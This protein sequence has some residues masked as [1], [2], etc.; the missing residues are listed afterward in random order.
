MIRQDYDYTPRK[1]GKKTRQGT[2]RNTKYGNMVSKKYYKKK[3]R[4]QG[5]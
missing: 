1:L 2:G 3:P 5:N 4:G